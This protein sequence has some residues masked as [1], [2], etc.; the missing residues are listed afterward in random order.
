M[1]SY[2]DWRKQLQQRQEAIAKM[3]RA[4][5]RATGV[6]D[7]LL[8][9]VKEEAVTDLWTVPVRGFRH[10]SVPLKEL[11]NGKMYG[12]LAGCY[13]AE[14]WDIGVN[15]AKCMVWERS[16]FI[17]HRMQSCSCG[18][19]AVF[20]PTKT[21]YSNYP[22]SGMIE[23]WG[24]V[25]LGPHGFRAQKAKIVALSIPPLKREGHVRVRVQNQWFLIPK[26]LP[27]P[28][29]LT[30][31]NPDLDEQV[32]AGLR[33]AYESVPIFDNITEMMKEFPI[34]RG[35]V[36]VEEEP[37]Y[38]GMTWQQQAVTVTRGGIA[39]NGVPASAATHGGHSTYQQWCRCAMCLAIRDVL[40]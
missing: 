32:I 13:H 3:R 29:G 20:D 40:E 4:F 21:G 16:H 31:E 8:R 1:E 38:P 25:I 28:E 5:A 17:E 27:L 2:D 12:W 26:E 9:P 36:P 14:P 23:G 34:D 37:R 15:E 10:F 7:E 35:E 22:V 24:E 18:F 6:P 30:D 19:Y 33:H 11:D 39:Y